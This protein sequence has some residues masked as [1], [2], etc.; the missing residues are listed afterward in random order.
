MI[1]VEKRIKT[2]NF[3]ERMHFLRLF[4]KFLFSS[5]A[6]T[7]TTTGNNVEMLRGC[8]EVPYQSLSVHDVNCSELN[9]IIWKV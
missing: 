5:F 6:T 8:C 4:E 2:N 7:L 9:T 1:G 3:S